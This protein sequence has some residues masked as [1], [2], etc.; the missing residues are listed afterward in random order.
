[1]QSSRRHRPKC[2]GGVAQRGHLGVGGRVGV[3]LTGVAPAP[4]DLPVDVQHDGP[5]GHVA[6]RQSR[7]GLVERETHGLLVV[8]P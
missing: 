2:R 5:D 6:G 8:D 7:P 4:D 1:M 3:R